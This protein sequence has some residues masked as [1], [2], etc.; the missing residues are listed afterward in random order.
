VSEKK[1]CFVVMGFGKK[2]DYSTGRVLDLDKSYRNIIKPAAIAAGLECK[3]ADEILH[4]GVI[5][6]PMYQQLLAA[7]VVV[8]DIS[9]N[10]CNA[11]Y[12]LG[13]RHALRP[14]T[15]I[16]IAEDQMVY[17]FDVNHIAV[18]KYQHLGPGIDSEE[19]DRM[20]GELTKAMQAIASKPSDDSPVYTF[21][22]GLK[23]PFVEA[24]GAVPEGVAVMAAPQP[25]NPES[26][27][28]P[29]IS[30]LMTQAE[31]AL[32]KSDFVTARSLLTVVKTMMP[33]EPHV[34]QRLALATYKSKL[35]TP[36][37]AAQEACR[38]LYELRPEITTDSETLGLWGATHK[39]LWELT[40]DRA[41]LDK[42]ITSLEKGFYLKNDYYN[43]I[44]LAFLLNVR[45]KASA[46]LGD[47]V[48][49][50]VLAERTRRHVIT[51]CENLVAREKSLPD[52]YWIYATMAEAYLGIG[53]KAKSGE[54]LAKAFAL[55]PEPAQWMRETTLGQLDNLAKLLE[56][57]PLSRVSASSSAG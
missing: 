44:N 39:R 23:P 36:V 30:V 50:F 16:T 25:L 37:E 14:Y 46:E 27:N 2:T 32:S 21:I 19:V 54:N 53:D 26:A 10:N 9:T 20:R 15:T 47:A 55:Q 48:A 11:F 12:E 13:V 41:Y 5:D 45:S 43:G 28:N 52:A 22:R 29:T 34:V 56:N 38:L 51:L 35:P 8:A 42:A 33:T 4:S 6:V 3:R 40:G 18:R 49:D 57:P 31:T 1:T 7:D 17:P 24:E